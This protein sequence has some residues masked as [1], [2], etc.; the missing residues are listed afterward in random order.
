MK[1]ARTLRLTKAGFC[2]ARKPMADVGDDADNA[3]EWKVRTPHRTSL[4]KTCLLVP[5]LADG[6]K[7]VLDPFDFFIQIFIHMRFKHFIAG[8]TQG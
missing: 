1:E 4:N 7:G 2:E 8:I 5:A 6:A 3:Y